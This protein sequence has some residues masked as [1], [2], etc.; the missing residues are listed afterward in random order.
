M[1]PNDNSKMAD[2]I[3]DTEVSAM[4]DLSPPPLECDFCS[5]E[6]FDYYPDEGVYLAIFDRETISPSMAV[7]GAVSTVA[8]I[9]PLD[10]ECSVLQFD[11]DSLDALLSTTNATDE[12]INVKLTVYDHKVMLNSYGSIIVQ[13]PCSTASD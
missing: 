7:L 10:T 13:P 1:S 6:S 12:E 8:E 9:D 5:F 4:L 11:I 2:G 3:S